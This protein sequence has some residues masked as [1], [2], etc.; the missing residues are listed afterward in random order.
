MKKTI[1]AAGAALAAC[2][3]L[4]ELGAAA[5]RIAEGTK[6]FKGTVDPYGSIRFQALPSKR[7][8]VPRL[9]RFHIKFDCNDGTP[10][11]GLG[12]GASAGSSIRPDDK[13]RFRI[14]DQGPAFELAVNGDFNRRYTKA[15]GTFRFQGDFGDG[16][17]TECDP[18]RL[19]WQ[20]KLQR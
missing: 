13:G 19:S 16:V 1:A 17:H 9:D 11:T 7:G 3:T 6:V 2:L 5:P 14:R 4:S 18:G 20:A 10:P 12:Y 15:S 8:K